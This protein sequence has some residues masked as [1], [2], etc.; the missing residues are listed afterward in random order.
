MIDSAKVKASNWHGKSRFCR[1]E[2]W[3]AEEMRVWRYWMMKQESNNFDWGVERY[4][5]KTESIKQEV[6]G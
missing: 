4:N 3:N 2:H 1:Q 6:R 5:W